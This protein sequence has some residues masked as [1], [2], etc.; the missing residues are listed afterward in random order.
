ME[1]LATIKIN[2]FNDELEKLGVGA[3]AS[4]LTKTLPKM[5]SF[6]KGS[7][8]VTGSAQRFLTRAGDKGWGARKTM[9]RGIE[10]AA[11]K[12]GGPM[13][14]FSKIDLNNQMKTFNGKAAPTH[15][16]MMSRPK[17]LGGTARGPVAKEIQGKQYA[18]FFGEGSNKMQWFKDQPSKMVGEAANNINFAREKGVGRFIK[19]NLKKSIT[20]EKGG[21]VYK[22]SPIGQGVGLAFSGPGFGATSFA[23]GGT[24]AAGQKQGLGK[25]TGSALGEAALW[26]VAPMAAGA[27]LLP[28]FAG[29]AGG[30]AKSLITR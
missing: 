10:G 24:N 11:K 19:H 17:K 4:L 13:Q 9:S 27:A 22:R 3:I 1:K 29:M 6:A 15:H 25:R 14:D 8:G 20:H 7:K 26:S 12:F 28:E 5:L 23:L 30:A 21:F 18:S 2:A 16:N